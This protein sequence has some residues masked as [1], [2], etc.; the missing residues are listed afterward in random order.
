MKFLPFTLATLIGVAGIAHS[1]PVSY[2]CEESAITEG[3]ETEWT[4]VLDVDYQT[5]AFRQLTVKNKTYTGFT[6]NTQ[7]VNVWNSMTRKGDAPALAIYEKDYDPRKPNGTYQIG[8]FG[9]AEGVKAGDVIEIMPPFDEPAYYCYKKGSLKDKIMT[10]L[11]RSH[12]AR[13]TG[14]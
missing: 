10:G 2:T 9:A 7:A 13:V 14:Q 1:A 4:A 5:G 3:L 12:N 8:L 6:M 11:R